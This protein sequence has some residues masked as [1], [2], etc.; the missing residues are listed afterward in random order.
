MIFV[1]YDYEFLCQELSHLF[2]LEVRAY[3]KGKV[4]ARRANYY[5]EPDVDGLVANEFKGQKAN[6]F[7]IETEELLVFGVVKCRKDDVTLV[8]GPTFRTR[9]TKEV[10]VSLLF[11]LGQSFDR[12]DDLQEYFANITPQP[13]ETFLGIVSFINY[14]LNKEK[15]P[16]TDMIS[17]NTVAASR[18]RKIG[19]DN[20]QKLIDDDLPRN[21]YQMERQMLSYI[22]AGNVAA[23]E[24]MI[25]APPTGRAGVLA[26]SE[27]RQRKNLVICTATLMSRAA[28]EGGLPPEDA[29]ALSD[30]Y[31]QKAELMKSGSDLSM[32]NGQMVLDYTKRVEG[33]KCGADNS[34]FARSIMRFV[35]N[36]ISK[37]LTTADIAAE[38]KMNRSHMCTQFKDETGQTVGQFITGAKIGEAK[39]LIKTTS[40]SSSHIS[41]YLGFS[42]Q[43]YFQTVFKKVEGCTPNEY[44]NKKTC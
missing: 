26:Q 20:M 19:T 35:L 22:S 42:T 29:F 21:T 8:I 24:E 18:H 25:D 4:F 44:R 1:Q 11:Q 7:Y 40:L 2:G 34:R 15:L 16:F 28:I 23:I 38:L 10:S 39:R 27:L 43:S 12:L 9:P 3:T 31:I 14:T 6:A 17:K 30:M 36:N 5:F 33:I 13:F 32:L 41:D 37:K